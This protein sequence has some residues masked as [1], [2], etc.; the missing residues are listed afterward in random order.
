MFRSIDLAWSLSSGKKPYFLHPSVLWDP[1]ITAPYFPLPCDLYQPPMDWDYR[2]AN[3]FQDFQHLSLRINRNALKR[4]RH[5]PA[6]FQAVLTSLQSRLAHLADIVET[7]IE[8]LVR[9]TMLALMTTTFKTPGRKLP[10]K[11]IIGRLGEVYEEAAGWLQHDLPL[12]IWVLVTVPFTITGAQPAWIRDAWRQTRVGLD[13]QVVKSYLMRVIWI[14]LIH[15]KPGEAMFQE[16]ESLG[17]SNC[18]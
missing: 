11:W 6:C 1:I 13:W 3:V 12:H 10:Y 5:D 15:D 18:T 9:L 14:E 7:P 8:E 4:A 16:L 2:L 17:Y